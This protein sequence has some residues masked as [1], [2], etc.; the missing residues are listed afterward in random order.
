MGHD[1]LAWLDAQLTEKCPVPKI[2]SKTTSHAARSRWHL[3]EAQ[4]VRER[5]KEITFL[6]QQALK[7]GRQLPLV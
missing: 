5:A 1:A 3:R 4:A 7:D 6:I 2:V